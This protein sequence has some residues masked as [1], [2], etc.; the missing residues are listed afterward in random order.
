MLAAPFRGSEQGELIVCNLSRSSP[1]RKPMCQTEA[2]VARIT[3]ADCASQG[4]EVHHH[5]LL[6]ENP[7]HGLVWGL[8]EIANALFDST[9]DYVEQIDRY[10]EHQDKPTEAREPVYKQWTCACA[11]CGT[12]F[13]TTRANKKYC[14]ALCYERAHSETRAACGLRSAGN[15]GSRSKAIGSVRCAAAR[16]YR[17]IRERNIVPPS[18]SH[19]VR[20]TLGATPRGRRSCPTSGAGE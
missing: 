15:R 10:K 18:A 14:S 4:L 7:Y 6:P 17:Q 19:A 16:S 1:S 11:V 2:Y 5:P 8:V 3:V 9:R 13:H 12:P 20:Q